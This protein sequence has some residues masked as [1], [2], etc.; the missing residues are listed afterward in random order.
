MTT[1]QKK[2]V[3]IYTTPTCVYCNQAKDFFAK[4]DISFTA[5]DVSTDAGKRTEMIEKTGQM[6]VPVIVLTP[7]DSD[8]PEDVEI[9]IGFNKKHLMETFDVVEE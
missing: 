3:E 5:Y 9:I 6:G 8:N 1:A 7:T 2:T 4:H